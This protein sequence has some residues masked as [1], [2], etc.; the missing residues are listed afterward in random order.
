MV[1]PPGC[2]P[3]LAGIDFQGVENHYQCAQTAIGRLILGQELGG[4]FKVDIG[5]SYKLLYTIFPLGQPHPPFEPGETGKRREHSW[6]SLARCIM[7][8]SLFIAFW[9]P[10]N[11][12]GGGE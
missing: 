8:L 4:Q 7:G 10:N 9:P 1:E 6:R 5:I 2:F 11:W 12:N 3:H